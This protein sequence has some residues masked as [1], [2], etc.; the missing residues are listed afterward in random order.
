MYDGESAFNDLYLS[1]FLKEKKFTKALNSP[2]KSGQAYLV[3]MEK[4]LEKIGQND[5]K[6][7]YKAHALI[8]DEQIGQ[9]RRNPTIKDDVEPFWQQRLD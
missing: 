9:Q 1:P 6:T 7:H 4:Q 8:K 5:E 2:Y 3:T